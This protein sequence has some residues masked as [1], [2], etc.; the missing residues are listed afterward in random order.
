MSSADF[1]HLSRT[2][3]ASFARDEAGNAKSV[4]PGLY[5][6]SRFYLSVET[7]HLFNTCNVWTA[8]ALRAAGL[9]IT[10]ATVIWVE[11]LMSQARML[12]TVVQSGPEALE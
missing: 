5:G 1:E 9:P 10:P 6:N 3:V 8:K 7:Y 11:S 4:G 12:G 2:I